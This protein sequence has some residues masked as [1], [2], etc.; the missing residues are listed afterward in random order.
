MSAAIYT[1]QSIEKKDS[2]SIE[3]QIEFAKRYLDPNETFE[4]YTDA[5]FSGKNIMRPEFQNM[6]RGI[7]SGKYNKVIVYKLDRISRNVADFSWLMELMKKNN[8]TFISA[9]E[10]FALDT[11]AGRAMLYMTS[12]FAQMERES[13]SERVKDN[14][15]ERLKI[16]VIGGGPA[17]LGYDI[18]TSVICG[19]K[20]SVYI[21]NIDIEIVKTMFEIYQSPTTTLSDVKK[22]IEAKFERCIQTSDISRRLRNPTYVKADASIYNY[23]YKLGAIIA[24]DI[25]YFDGN[26]G[27]LIAGKRKANERKYTNVK[28]HV[29]TIGKHEGVI[30]STMFLYCQDKL[31]KNRQIKNTFRGQYSWLSGLVKCGECGRAMVVKRYKRKDGYVAKF[32][33]SS[34][35]VTGECIPHNHCVD[36]IEELIHAEIKDKIKTIGN[37]E[38][39]NKSSINQ[40]LLVMHTQITDINAKIENLVL[41]LEQAGSASIKYI[42][43]RIEE[44]DAKKASVVANMSSIS[45]ELDKIYAPHIDENWTDL[46]LQSKKEIARSLIEKVSIYPDN[47]IRIEWKF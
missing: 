37:L 13:T 40:K 25:Q 28:D 22:A 9:K 16:G 33:C 42:N 6:L 24:S 43:S 39:Y 38:S 20:H 45:Y 4:I 5:G 12:T 11:P 14:Y 35:T 27:C 1:R 21:A 26:H 19:R 3:T 18:S 41:N 29:I 2:E 34:P 30:D 32:Y 44:L 36:E 47:S 15:Y 31:L 17:P 46:T 23:Y 10:N 7:E 8:C